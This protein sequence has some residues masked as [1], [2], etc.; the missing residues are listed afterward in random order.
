METLSLNLKKILRVKEKTSISNL[1]I[2]YI[3]MVYINSVL[4]DMSILWIFSE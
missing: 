4:S 3:D 2:N 1:S